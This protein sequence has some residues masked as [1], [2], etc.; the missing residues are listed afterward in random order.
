[1][2]STVLAVH[3]FKYQKADGPFGTC[4]LPILARSNL[5][6]MWVSPCRLTS[7]TYACMLDVKEAQL[8]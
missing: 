6:H 8:Y 5:Q 7:L 1:M 3:R 4:T 2:Q